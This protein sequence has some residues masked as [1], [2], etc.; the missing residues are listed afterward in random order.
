MAEFLSPVSLALF[1]TGLSTLASLMHTYTRI[2]RMLT[3]LCHMCR[4]QA[5][6]CSKISWSNV[7]FYLHEQDGMKKDEQWIL[8]K[9]KKEGKT[10]R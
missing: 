5:H 10:L 3:N 8:L 7:P 6:H 9:K 4:I 1:T 2:N